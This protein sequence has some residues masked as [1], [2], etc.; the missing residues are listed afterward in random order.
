MWPLKLSIATFHGLVKRPVKLD[1]QILSYKNQSKKVSKVFYFFKVVYINVD[2]V[3][4][5]KF[6]L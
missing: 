4:N 2:Y 6:K 3:I 1:I 5:K